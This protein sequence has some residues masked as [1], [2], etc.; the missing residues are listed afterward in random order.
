MIR[1]IT[2]RGS[3]FRKGLG[4][5]L[6]RCALESV[7]NLQNIIEKWFLQG[8]TFRKIYKLFIIFR[9]VY[10]F[11][12]S[13][14]LIQLIHLELENFQDVHWNTSCWTYWLSGLIVLHKFLWISQS[15]YKILGL[16]GPLFRKYIGIPDFNTR[17]SFEVHLSFGRRVTSFIVE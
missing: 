14:F 3:V 4:H 5:I 2:V 8:K 17:K 10:Y 16:V 11:F 1:R 6:D 13:C 7:E 9:T 12:I 15:L